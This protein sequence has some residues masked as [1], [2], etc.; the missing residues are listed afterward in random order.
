MTKPKR[1]LDFDQA[2]EQ[3][4]LAFLAE[5]LGDKSAS[6][7]TGYAEYRA[8]LGDLAN[9]RKPRVYASPNVVK[10]QGHYYD[11]EFCMWLQKNFDYLCEYYQRNPDFKLWQGS[12][13]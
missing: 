10:E 12:K 6:V 7:A 4:R 8:N 11:L 9:S 13:A 3:A 5:H 2:V 1:Q